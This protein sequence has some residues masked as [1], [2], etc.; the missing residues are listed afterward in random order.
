[1]GV[2]HVKPEGRR[3]ERETAGAFIEVYSS[4]VGEIPVAHVKGSPEQMGRQYGELVGDKIRRN[5][6]RT[7]GLFAELGL[8][9]ELLILLLDKSWKRLE[10]HTPERYLREMAAIPQGAQE[11][12]F[13]VSLADIQRLTTVTNFDL[14][15]REER[16]LE[17]LGEDAAPILERMREMDGGG[18]PPMSCTMFAAWGSRTVDGKL[19]AHRNLDWVSQTGMHEDRLITVYRPENRLAFVTMGYAGVVGALAGMNE[20]GICFSEIGAFSLSEEL[21]GTPWVLIAREA[22]EESACLEEAVA[23]VRN[24]KHTIGYNYQVAD[25]DPDRFGTPEFEPRA[26]VLETNFECCETFFEDDPK[27]HEA[28]W[29]DPDGNAINYGLPLKEAVMR[30][31]MAFGKRTRELQATDNGPGDPENDGNPLEGDTYIQ[32]HRAMH[33]MIRAYGAGAEYVYPLRGTKVIDAGEPRTMG[34]EEALTIAATV[35]H[36]TERLAERDWDVMSVVFAATD[37]E[38]WVSYESCDAGGNWKNAPDSGYV[39]FSLRELLAA[40]P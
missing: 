3:I 14:Y 22:L 16:A 31:D 1:M 27:E 33:D 34:A 9:E 10:P 4:A 23:I 21:D 13:D 36:N 17:F 32:Y 19:L 11:A 20:K 29:T 6:D 8:P 12:G 30:A 2:L 39:Q 37:L 38:F 24:A 7:V 28:S 5:I 25:G 15:K 18:S 26:A 35:A 40:E